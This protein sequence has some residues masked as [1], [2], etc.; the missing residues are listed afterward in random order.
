MRKLPIV[1]CA[2][3]SA[4]I[5]RSQTPD[6]SNVFNFE[7][8]QL[9]G[10]QGWGAT[11]DVVL[12][13]KIAHSGK[14]AARIDRRADSDTNS[15]S[16]ISKSMPME[17][18]G[19]TLELRAFLRTEN[20][21][22]F[23]GMW[24]RE[25]GDSGP[26]EFDNMQKRELRGT[27]DWKEYSI[28]LPVNSSGKRL[29][30]GVFVAGTGTAWVDD[31]QLLVDA[32]PIWEAPHVERPKTPLDTDHEFDSGSRVALSALK[33]A[34]IDN[35]VTLGKVWGF[36]K[37]HHPQIT[38][39]HRHWDYDLF[40]VMPAV[41]QAQDRNSANDAIKKWIDGLGEM[42]RC[43][44]C[45]VLD[46]GDLHF[47]PELKWIEDE[48]R[49]GPDLSKALRVVYT[50]RPANKNQFYLSQAPNVGNPEFHNEPAYPNAKPGD[51]GFQILAAFR[52][53]NI[54][55]YWF[56]YRD[57]IGEDW[58]GV[59]RDTLPAIA[60]AKT[61][62]EYHRALMA[63]IARAHDTHSN[64]WSSIADRPPVGPCALPVRLRFIENQPVVTGYLGQPQT[65]LKPGDVIDELDS[66][67]V[68]KLVGPW[69]PYYADSNDAA[70]RRDV[71]TQ[72]TRGACGDTTL[73]VR[74]ANEVISLKTERVRIA[75]SDMFGPN[76]HDRSGETFQ[77][78]SP[79]V[80][81]LKLSSVKIAD[82]PK[83]VDAA[84]G[85][86]GL[87]IDIRN[88]PSEF[89]VFALGQ[90]LVDKPAPFARF[91]AADLANPGAFYWRGNPLSLTPQQ[92]HYSG[93]VVILV[94]ESSQSQAEYTTMAFRTAP[95]A[96]VVGSMT[97]GADGNVSAIPLPGGLRSMISGI[98]VFYPD[99]R[100]TQ[101]VG[102]IPDVEVKPTIAGIRAGRDEVLDEAIR[103]IVGK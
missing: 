64:L 70:M 77:K 28:T 34:Q 39:G 46:S 43:S 5:C 73:R 14:W 1:L 18:A 93:K 44:P 47:G 55:E 11:G 36:L 84:A 85:T 48:A 57:V 79:E 71:A 9:T 68:Q 29:F 97:A 17:F 45:A 7:S 94:D 3:L 102:I 16:G 15:I 42:A 26:V 95:G 75:D 27:N 66:T 92:P 80:A 88:Y 65:D 100:P 96:K 4:A 8:G 13:D 33:P 83:Y 81:Y 6:L 87:I 59:L 58:D 12:D 101:R 2:C 99:K 91:T 41:L 76:R 56:P 24:M 82:A 86:K 49:L 98:G 60:L 40:R 90:L 10:A 78:L 74:R 35:L 103:L 38:S 37:Y 31:V 25:D 63:L 72:M 19:K 62:E 21:T 23:V 52:Y 53:W 89:M 30:Y 67:P 61:A 32:K 54:I 69:K 20:V 51:A 22:S 50:N